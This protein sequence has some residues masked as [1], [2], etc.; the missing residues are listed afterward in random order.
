YLLRELARREDLRITAW[1]GSSPGERFGVPLRPVDVGDA[2]A[3]ARAFADAR[4]DVVLHAAA[5]SRVA[6][7]QRDPA[8]AHRVNVAGSATL[9]ALADAARARFVQVSTDLVFDGAR[10]GYRED[11]PPSP[12]SVYGRSK[13]DAEAPALALA[14]GAVARISLLYGPSLCGR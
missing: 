6:D 14:R 7:C 1:S 2:G 9:A 5:L 8:R 13:A 10:G 12:V 4:P 3:L 11:D